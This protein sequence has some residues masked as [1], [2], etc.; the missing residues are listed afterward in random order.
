MDRS[1]T[2]IHRS[3]VDTYNHRRV[4]GQRLGP[5]E[6]IAKLGEG[7]MGVVY[8]ARDTKLGRQ[9]AL[10]V[11]PPAFASDA[12]YLARF[13]REGRLLAAVNHPNIATLYGVEET[14][15]GTALVMEFVDGRTL[16]DCIAEGGAGR[17]LPIEMAVPV[18]RQIAD[19]MS[20]AHERGIV[21]RD[22]KPGNIKITSGSVVKVLD[23]GLAKTDATGAAGWGSGSVDLTR[24]PTVLPSGTRAGVIMG[25]AAYM[26]PEQARG[27]AVDHRTDIWALGC[28]L[29]E[30]LTGRP[31]FEGET[32]TDVIASILRRDPEWT[33]LPSTTPPSLHRALTRCLAKDPARRL[34]AIADVRFDLDEAEAAR[35]EAIERTPVVAVK[36]DLDFQRITDFVGPKETPVVSPDGKM[37]AFVAL[38]A[39]RRQIWIRL[40][41]GG[42][43]LQ[44][45]RD[46]ED[47]LFPRWAPDSSTL[48]YFTPGASPLEEGT[49]FEIGALGGWPRPVTRALAGADISHDG[50]RLAVLRAQGDQLVLGTSSRAGSDFEVVTRLPTAVYTSLRWSPDDRS[51]A[52]QRA[53]YEKGFDVALEVV[54]LAGGERA[55]V[56]RDAALNGFAWLSD[57][58]GFVYSSSRGSTLI[59]PPVCNLRRI[60]RDGSGDRQ[61]TCGDDSLLQPDVDANGRLLASRLRMRSDIWRFP[62]TGSPLENTRDAV[63]ITKQ[64]GQVQVPSVSPDGSRLVYV[65]D[66]GGHGNLWV[67]NTDGSGAR[68][69]TFETEPTTS[70]GLPKWSPRGDVIAVV[71]SRGGQGG[72][73]AIRPDGSGLRH[74][75]HGW[76]PCWSGDGQWLYYCRLGDHVGQVERMPIDGGP[77]VVVRPPQGR[78]LALPAVS[79]DGST[80]FLISP[81]GERQFGVSFAY[82]TEIYRAQPEDAATEI[83]ARVSGNRVPGAPGPP[84]MHA[85]MS[86]DGHWLATSL[87]DGATT[88][89]WAL[90]TAGGPLR[91]LTDFG[92]RSVLITRSVSWSPDSQSVYAAVAD[93]QTDIVL[94]DGLIV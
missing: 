22:L 34:H 55:E 52:V 14:S 11:L 68:Q 12:E 20:A 81:V 57:G 56:V 23:F 31:P 24:S 74:L 67:A 33:A 70:M 94:I 51:I 17:G 32:V 8:G 27:V 72:L 83:V 69:I 9:V 41:A 28:V 46:D 7:G 80:L 21:H 1:G 50:R 10:K 6:V 37:V 30:M 82:M 76:A 38:I 29:F 47:H 66:N 64:T 39:G 44:L 63:R 5:Y 53:S 35:D 93:V 92:D 49:I 77:P 90:P 71:M 73:W 85:A 3:S 4:I 42:A 40:L 19:A 58:S 91:P 15:E 88:N 36:R 18:A 25:T 13:E 54:A 61:L 2:S 48:I 62:A 87:V 60:A 26:S 65:S 86:P 84:V 59:Y 89:L 45:T 43:L 16:A 78:Q 79:P 75:V